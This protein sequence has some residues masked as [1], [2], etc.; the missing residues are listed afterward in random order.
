MN[1]ENREFNASGDMEQIRYSN[2]TRLAF[3]KFG[4]RRHSI[5]KER[6]TVNLGGGVCAWLGPPRRR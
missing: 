4:S 6:L 2:K 3:A 5:V 1:R